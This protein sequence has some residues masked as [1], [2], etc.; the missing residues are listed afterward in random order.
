LRTLNKGCFEKSWIE[1]ESRRHRTG[2]TFFEKGI[3]AFELLGR[4]SQEG[5]DFVFKGGTSLL[6]RLPKPR[7]LSIDVDIVCRESADRLERI[8]KKCA[9][10]P[11]TGVEED[12]RHHN[13]PPRRRHWNFSYNSI[14]PDHC[15][16]PYIILDVL[17]EDCL[18][19][20]VDPVEIR[21]PFFTADH[22]IRV[23]VPTVDNL[24]ADKLTAFAPGTIG[25]E[26]SDE[27]P[28]KIVKHLFDIGELFNAAEQLHTIQRVYDTIAR[29]EIGY[30]QGEW[31]VTDCLGSTIQAA[32]LV[33]ALAVNQN[34]HPENSVRLRRGIAELGGHLLGINFTA[35][36]AAAA[37]GKAA[38]LATVIK[39]GATGTPIQ[40]LRYDRSKLAAINTPLSD[41]V[42]AKLAQVAPEAFYYWHTVE[43]LV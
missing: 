32:K 36:H 3:H 2:N 25:Q 4:L 12:A 11:F 1:A 33:T 30:R 14:T 16:E 38:L 41:P 5:L 40:D 37:A 8:L 34:L 43:T 28:E 15:P 23:R 19:P 20:D 21:T 13:R 31:S 9:G 26:Y 22:T 24:L 39:H 18:Y 35:V 27:H 6:L 42:F 29:A 10:T 7:R 17:E